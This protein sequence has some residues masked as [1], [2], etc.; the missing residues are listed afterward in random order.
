MAEY[1]PT[2]QHKR[3]NAAAMTAHNPTLAEGEFGVETDTLKIKVGDGQRAWNDLPYVSGLR[4]DT[5][6][7]LAEQNPNLATKELALGYKPNADYTAD[8]PEGQYVIKLNQS[9]TQTTT[10]SAAPVVPL[11]P[12]NTRGITGADRITN[13]VSMTMT[14]YTALPVK[15]ATTLY[16]IV[17]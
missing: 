12:S 4:V 11:V 16:I 6:Q 1:L 8:V 13:I 14:A 10:W 7:D 3:G 17:D 2:V 15:N 5:L 9:K